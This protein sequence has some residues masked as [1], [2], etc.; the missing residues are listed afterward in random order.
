[1]MTDPGMKAYGELLKNPALAYDNA[2]DGEPA[3]P[4]DLMAGLE[5]NATAQKNFMNFSQSS[6]RMFILWLNSAK[7]TETRQRRIEKIV[8]LAERNIK[9]AM[10]VI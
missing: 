10:G 2:S 9:P 4:D 8:S 7:R 3:I 5:K 1:L 6:R